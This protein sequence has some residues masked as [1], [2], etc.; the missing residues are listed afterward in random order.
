METYNYPFVGEIRIQSVR[1]FIVE[2]QLSKDDKVILNRT[3]LD[4]VMLEYKETYADGIVLPFNIVGVKVVEGN[5]PLNTLAFEKKSN[6]KD[7]PTRVLGF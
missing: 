6:L 2:N 4:D 3:N 7:E 1:K 5:T